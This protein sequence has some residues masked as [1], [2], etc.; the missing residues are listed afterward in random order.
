MNNFS[1]SLLK[2]NPIFRE[3]FFILSTSL[4]YV[5]MSDKT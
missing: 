2:L 3:E 4:R 1:M 5:N